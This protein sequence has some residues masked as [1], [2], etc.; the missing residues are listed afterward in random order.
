[1]EKFDQ[2]LLHKISSKLDVKDLFNFCLTCKKF[3]NNIYQ[4]DIIWTH[5]LSQIDEEFNGEILELKKNV[6]MK[7]KELYKMGFSLL[8]IAT[9]FKMDIFSLFAIFMA[10]RIN[11]NY[12]ECIK[13][14]PKCINILSDNLKILQLGMNKINHI[15][16]EIG[17]LVNLEHLDLCHNNIQTIPIEIGKLSKLTHLY[18]EHNKI[19]EIP[20]EIG[21]LNE[22][23]DFYINK[24][25]LSAIP[26]EICKLR[27]LKCLSISET[28]VKPLPE[29]FK[30]VSFAIF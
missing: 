6:K 1:M 25:P 12:Y 10:E 8:E 27:S 5:Y 2:L 16:K 4:K 9:E 19:R 7:N 15:P 21:N 14:I 17:D 28:N 11:L 30:N 24:N 23:K 3:Y 22:L 13:T 18:L 29:E 20:K 26:L